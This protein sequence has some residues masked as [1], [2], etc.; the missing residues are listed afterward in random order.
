MKFKLSML[1]VFVLLTGIANGQ[2][3]RYDIF[4]YENC[5]YDRQKKTY[6]DCKDIEADS[7]WWIEV[8]KNKNVITFLANKEIKTYQVKKTTVFLSSTE[9]VVTDKS[10]MTW[11]YQI[12]NV[13][14]EEYLELYVWQCNKKGELLY[15]LGKTSVNI[16][17][18]E[19]P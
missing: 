18:I 12:R 7:Y 8:D 9:Y 2:V 16:W 14:N 19:A 5:I 1:F 10:G 11:L 17:G 15:T 3:L 4:S 13:D 6:E